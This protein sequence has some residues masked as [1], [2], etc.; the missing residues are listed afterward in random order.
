MKGRSKNMDCNLLKKFNSLGI[1]LLVLI[2]PGYAG[3]K[4]P[5]AS[6]AP[7]AETRAAIAVDDTPYVIGAQDVLII[8][9]WHEPEVSA[10]LT[11][12]P[13]G[14]IS[15]PLAND[16]QAAGLSP[17]DLG[18]SITEKLKVYINNPQ[19]T[20]VVSAINSQRFYVVGE[21]SKPGAFPLLPNTTVLQALSSAG[22]FSQF[23]QIGKIY[24]L[25]SEGN[26]SVK[27]PFNYKEVVKGRSSGQNI[28]LKS[29][30]TIVIP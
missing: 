27:L 15:L 16:I 28:I 11:V 18:K 2:A 22:S 10:T 9:V 3:S 14:K 6:A 5:A 29:G 1:S 23:A 26:H 7:P 19:V 17:T 24:V 30:D 25:R 20:V 13:D 8:N 21:I 12:R 4:R